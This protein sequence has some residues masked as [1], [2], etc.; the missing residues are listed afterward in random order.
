M[1]TK[2][3]AAATKAKRARAVQYSAKL[4]L[5]ICDQI[6]NGA[7]LTTICAGAGMPHYATVMRWIL[8][9][10][11]FAKDYDRARELQADYL[12]EQVLEIADKAAV[13]PNKAKSTAARNQM[14]ARKWYAGKVRPKRWGDRVDVNV[15][16]QVRPLETLTDEE[17]DAEIAK[18]DAD[19]KAMGVGL[20]IGIAAGVA[21]ARATTGMDDAAG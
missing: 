6:A 18:A 13:R 8:V 21:A 17:L 3:E 15:E 10:P 9:H 20:S 4:A 1:A 5:D 16:A 11:D 19:L 12:A 7:A 14:D 2:G